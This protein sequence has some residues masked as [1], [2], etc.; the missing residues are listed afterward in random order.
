MQHLSTFTAGTL[1]LL[2]C[3][4]SNTLDIN[5]DYREVTVV[6]GLLDHGQDTNY[7]R[8]QKSFITETDAFVSAADPGANYY[9]NAIL[10]VWLAGYHGDVM[11]DS[12]FCEYVDGDSL[13][14]EK[15][16]GIF[17][18]S[19]N[20]LYRITTALDSTAQWKLHIRN[21][22][23]GALITAQTKLVWNYYLYYPTKAGAYIDFADTG[24]I[25]FTCAQAVNAMMYDLRMTFTYAE[26]NNISGD[27]TLHDVSWTI[28]DNKIGT[29]LNG[30]GN[31]S[32]TIERKSFYS[33]IRSAIEPGNDLTRYFIRLDFEWYAGGE[34][35]YDLY[36]NT[37]ANLGLNQDYISPE[38]TN[39]SGGY[40]IFS[41]RYKS[42]ASPVFLSD[43]SLDTLS[44]G[45]ITSDL[46]F[47]SSPSN[48]AYPGCAE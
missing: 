27:S 20:I 37:L 17:S 15:P 8:I 4:C 47:V 11:T 32:Y 41:S 45:V 25:T 1:L 12:I 42:I 14:I 31:I 29:N 39:I 34:E 22:E 26:V 7:L 23:T 48:P 43:N 16:D 18:A 36:L 10:D 33:F 6:I 9:A 13:G 3:G 44:C 5:G 24:K 28:F 30:L 19:P 35:L 40:G 2:F 46:G 21:N 38:Y